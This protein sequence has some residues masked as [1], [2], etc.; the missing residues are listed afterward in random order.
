MNLIIGSDNTIDVEKY[1]KIVQTFYTSNS[2]GWAQAEQVLDE[3]QRNE[4]SWLYVDKILQFSSSVQ[5]KYIALSVLDN[6][7]TG[8]WYEL[9]QEQKLGVRNFLVGFILYVC[10][11]NKPNESFM[12]RKADLVLI[13]I[14]KREWPDNW[15]SFLDEL[16]SSSQ[17]SPQVCY[18]NLKILSLL[19][20]EVFKPLK[21]NQ[22]K[23]KALQ[24][25]Y[26]LNANAEK[27]CNFC[28]ELLKMDY[29][30]EMTVASLNTIKLF[31]LW[32]PKDC[33]NSLELWGVLTLL[34]RSEPSIRY[35]VIQCLIQVLDLDFA[36]VETIRSNERFSSSLISCFISIINQTACE[37]KTTDTKWYKFYLELPIDGEEYLKELAKFLTKFLINHSTAMDNTPNVRGI[38]YEA[39]RCIL[40]LMELPNIEI[41]EYTCEY[42]HQLV[43]KSL[44]KQQDIGYNLTHTHPLSQRR[45]SIDR[46]NFEFFEEVREYL[47]WN[48]TK[49]DDIHNLFAST[50]GLIDESEQSNLYN[51]QRETLIYLTNLEYTKT[52]GMIQNEINQWLNQPIT[53][54]GHFNSVC[55]SIATLAGQLP[56]KIEDEFIITIMKIIM[57]IEEYNESLEMKTHIQYNMIYIITKYTRFLKNN[58]ISLKA[59]TDRLIIIIQSAATPLRDQAAIALGRLL[60]Q[61]ASSYI[62]PQEEN[63]PPYIDIIIRQSSII[64]GYLSPEQQTQLIKS[65][66]IAVYM[67]PRSIEKQKNTDLIIHDT[68]NEWNAV[69]MKFRDGINNF[70]D[71]ARLQ[72][73]N[74]LI[75][76]LDV[77]CKELKEYFNSHLER[78]IPDISFLL[79][80]LS[81]FIITYMDDK[82]LKGN[83]NGSKNLAI[84][85]YSGILRLLNASID[86]GT[87][88]NSQSL[89]IR[90]SKIVDVFLST[91]SN[92]MGQILNGEDINLSLALLK[93]LG[94]NFDKYDNQLLT[95]LID[96]ALAYGDRASPDQS[97]TLV[98]SMS[99]IIGSCFETILA[100][101]ASYCGD[102]CQYTMLS[103]INSDSDVKLISWRSLISILNKFK[104]YKDDQI[105]NEFLASFYFPLLQLIFS[106]IT[107]KSFDV[108][109]EEQCQ[110]LSDLLIIASENDIVLYAFI[111]SKNDTNFNVVQEFLLNEI[112]NNSK[113]K[114]D[115]A[116]E[117]VLSLI[118]LAGDR[119]AIKNKLE[120]FKAMSK[121][122]CASSTDV[123][124]EENYHQYEVLIKSQ[125][126]KRHNDYTVTD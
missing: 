59:I 105:Q 93:K 60:A 31:L 111:T 52:L 104:S 57:Q 70:N 109:F 92:G 13:E 69:L 63:E 119:N 122:A 29:S 43:F 28:T 35:H 66:Q 24:L 46:D 100:L 73:L 65:L 81:H 27:I 7:V 23:A 123:F 21:K 102:I 39:H 20:E 8:G 82:Q 55:W 37:I 74:H 80:N 103:A 98:K 101:K 90:A 3:F 85:I 112:L 6:M 58:W 30:S 75:H 77:T 64:L 40:R 49:P 4:D 97:I 16:I 94:R 95:I 106:T 54:I 99:Y 67:D 120:D 126:I 76:V 12:L 108:V 121:E 110:L 72:K 56:S 45:N 32:L 17:S 83:N 11:K 34:S 18:N 79:Q 38:I 44:T 115:Q 124:E 87:N 19:A 113:L 10:E 107:D 42:W 68:L 5:G 89:T 33:F 61:C 48:L 1:D 117:I 2:Q 15:T 88:E 91:Y 25:I 84:E 9:P 53:Q 116:H 50:T 125:A 96:S 86:H 62:Y 36:L 114:A 118:S 26:N 14:L 51:I 78:I 47:I 71:M 41:L 22:T